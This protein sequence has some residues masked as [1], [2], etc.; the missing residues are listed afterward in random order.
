MTQHF[1]DKKV[2]KRVKLV[3]VPS[4][5]GVIGHGEVTIT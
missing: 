4:P 1:S 3:L 5:E 2:S